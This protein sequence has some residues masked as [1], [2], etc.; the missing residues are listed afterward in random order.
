MIGD[1]HDDPVRPARGHSVELERIVGDVETFRTSVWGKG[2]MRRTMSLDVDAEAVLTVAMIDEWLADGARRPNFRIVKT[3]ATFNE[4]EYTRSVR[5]G[6]T[7]V[8]GVADVE[9]IAALVAG[10]ATL[11]MQNLEYAFP[12]VRRVVDDLAHVVSH[13]V[14]ANAYLTPPSA[15][16]LGRHADT[17]DVLIVQIDGSKT[18]EV[19]GLGEFTVAPGDVIYIP[20]GT[21]HVARTST[22]TSLH[23][24]LGVLR[25]TTRSVLRRMLDQLEPDIDD[26]LPLDY[27]Q[28]PIDELVD[29]LRPRIEQAIVTLASTD[30]ANVARV[31]QER[32]AKRR[33]SRQRSLSSALASFDLTQ[34]SL[35]HK[36]VDCRFQM[37]D[38][39][40]VLH[41]PDRTVSFPAAA[42]PALRVLCR[43]DDLSVGQLIGIDESSRVVVARR[44]IREGAVALSGLRSEEDGPERG[45]R[46]HQRTRPAV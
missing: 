3:G 42:A 38:D 6:G 39:R 34:N 21:P 23:L 26:A 14:Q 40:A 15:A 2:P 44:L 35:L 24:T 1:K 27:A 20:R 32:A 43:S 11:V 30:L 25:V 28:L 8:E 22:Q 46:Q 19:D 41:L 12:N 13:P 18:W 29:V 7:D 4:R 5:M 36:V 9:A 45:K 17:H 10:G 33:P 16:G 37:V 31:E